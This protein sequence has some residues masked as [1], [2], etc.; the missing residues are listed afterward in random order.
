VVALAAAGSVLVQQPAYAAGESILSPGPLSLVETGDQLNCNVNHTGDPHSEWFQSPIRAPFDAPADPID[1]A[2]GTF[3]SAAG[4]NY[5][6]PTVPANPTVRTGWTPVGQSGVT[7]A[8]TSTSP[9]R[10][11]T[12]VDAGTSGV[13]FTQT[14]SYVTGEESYRTDIVVTNNSGTEVSGVLYRAGDCYLQGSDRGFG[15]VDTATG[16]ISC[17]QSAAPNSRIE[18]MLPITANSNYMEGAFNTVWTAVDSGNPF[19]N[20]CVCPGSEIDNGMGLSWPVALP[21]GASQTYSSLLTFSPVGRTPLTVTKTAD[22]ATAPAGGTD[23]YTITITNPNIADATVNLSDAL[24]TG[25]QYRPGTTTGATTAD[26]GTDAQGLL[27]S[28]IPVLAHSRASIHFGVIVSSVPGTYTN[29]VEGSATGFTVANPGPTAPVTVVRVNHPPVANNASTATFNDTPVNIQLSAS[30]PDGD[31]LTYAIVSQP[32]HGTLSGQPPDITY[33]SEP[34]FVGQDTFTFD[35]SDGELTSNI[36]T[37]T[38][39]VAQRN[40]PPVANPQRVHTF[41]DTAVDIQLTASDP[42]GDEL[43]YA[44]ATNPAHGTLSGQPPNVTYTPVPGF[45][46]DDSFTFTASDG[47]GEGGLTSEPATVSITVE[48]SNRPPEPNSATFT[49]FDNTPVNIQLT[50]S[51]PDEDQL[52]YAISTQPEHGTLSGDPPAVTYTPAPDFVGT[53][54]FRFTANDGE[55]TSDPATITIIVLQSN[56]VPMPTPATIT[57]TTGTPINIPLTGIDADENPLTFALAG[58][59]AHGT[60]TG[61]PPIVTYQSAPGY[62]GPDS[63]TFTAND[64]ALTSDPATVTINVV[65]G[66][67]PP[68]KPPTATAA[69]VS[70]PAGLAVAVT[71][72]GRDPDGDAL[73]FTTRGGPAHGKLTGTAPNLT[74]TPAADFTGQDSIAFTAS[75]GKATSTPARVSITVTPPPTISVSPFTAEFGEVVTAQLA[76]FPANTD[77]S[78]AVPGGVPETVRTDAKGAAST[79]LIIIGRDTVGLVQVTATTDTQNATCDLVLRPD[80]WGPPFEKDATNGRRPE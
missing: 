30:D 63:F 64:G 25:F 23:G 21:P 51:D 80:D 73:T 50:A 68:N 71:L 22:A 38:I 5:G 28:G 77:V 62:V 6:P 32:G 10:M 44:I 53:D 37:V 4:V 19:P 11:S 61:T 52:S 18:Q 39:D 40:R 35:A 1:T 15:A 57:V 24:P 75:D 31:A 67:A 42:D 69:S 8:G 74:Y 46:G 13:R 14:D 36:A 58:Q 48:Q 54:T 29:L 12:V 33:T 59:P 27:W 76:G 20:T 16:A 9:F 47:D 45:T 65:P 60:L 56:R 41:N 55:V 78:V 17:T 49:T 26:P 66:E 34:G 43:S 2:C 70:T 3:F 7:G 72:T 79:P